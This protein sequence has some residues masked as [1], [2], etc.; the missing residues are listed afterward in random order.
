MRNV[1][2]YMKSWYSPTYDEFGNIRFVVFGFKQL[3][4]NHSI[5]AVDE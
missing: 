4:Y 2:Q 5:Q 1:V 3:S